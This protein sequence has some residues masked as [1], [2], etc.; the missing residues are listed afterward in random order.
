MD[1]NAHMAT[2]GAEMW[3]L[4]KYAG[5]CCEKILQSLLIVENLVQYSL[6][7]SD[8][9]RKRCLWNE[10]HLFPA[11]FVD[12]NGK[13]EFFQF[14]DHQNHAKRSCKFMKVTHRNIRN[15]STCDSIADCVL[16]S[17][18]TDNACESAYI[19]LHQFH[20]ICPFMY[21]DDVCA[22]ARTLTMYCRVC[23]PNGIFALHERERQRGRVCWCVR[24]S[25]TIAA[26]VARLHYA[27]SRIKSEARELI[28]GL[29]N[30]IGGNL[31][32]LHHSSHSPKPKVCVCVCVYVRV[33]V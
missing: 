24:T 3:Y 16:S 10:N 32:S 21:Q 2:N 13:I 17:K 19:F 7:V 29:E 15:S 27:L 1:T 9:S 20:S 4:E 25:D 11:N 31:V 23:V 8:S 5:I 22:R 18:Q 30:K 28:I 26:V 14:P 12:S 6:A 33:R